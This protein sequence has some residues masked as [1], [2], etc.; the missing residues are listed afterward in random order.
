MMK[1]FHHPLAR[2]DLFLKGF[3]LL[4]N[5]I[6]TKDSHVMRTLARLRSKVQN[7]L[8]QIGLSPLNTYC[9]RLP[10]NSVECENFGYCL[11]WFTFCAECA[12]CA[13]SHASRYQH[14]ACRYQHV[15]GK[16]FLQR[17]RVDKIK[18]GVNIYIN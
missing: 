13:H 8:T 12:K 18:I 16:N 9:G 14:V 3:A 17:N 4:H 15:A 6:P 5:F 10:Q 11:P 7:F 2:K 1:H